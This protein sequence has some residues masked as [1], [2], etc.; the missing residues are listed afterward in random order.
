MAVVGTL[1][2]IGVDARTQR[3]PNGAGKMPSNG[4]SGGRL[5]A[6]GIVVIPAMGADGGHRQRPVVLRRPGAG[7]QLPATGSVAAIRT[8]ADVDRAD[9]AGRENQSQWPPT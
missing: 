4:R 6:A 8:V 9:L 1:S 5:G 2:G 7:G 3:G